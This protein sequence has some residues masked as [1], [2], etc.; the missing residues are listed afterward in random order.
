MSDLD[1]MKT[2]EANIIFGSNSA[3]YLNLYNSWNGKPFFRFN[4]YFFLLGILWMINRTMFKRFRLFYVV[5]WVYIALIL[6]GDASIAIAL[7]SY[8]AL[9]LAYSPISDWVYLLNAKKALSLLR[10]DGLTFTIRMNT[11][12]L[13]NEIRRGNQRLKEMRW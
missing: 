13:A 2:E 9:Q 10:R 5:P 8:M 3:Y 7:I 6:P 12:T 1:P 4:W 11:G